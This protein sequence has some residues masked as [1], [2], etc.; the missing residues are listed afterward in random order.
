MQLILRLLLLVQNPLIHSG[1][2]SGTY[3]GHKCYKERGDSQNMKGI[4]YES[5][6]KTIH[7][8]V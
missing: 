7:I 1:T 6:Q 2:G 4:G 8:I 3:E 5:S